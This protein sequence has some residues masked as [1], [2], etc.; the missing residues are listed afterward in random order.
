MNPREFSSLKLWDQHGKFEQCNG[1]V[2]SVDEVVS[3]SQLHLA[4]SDCLVK[5]SCD[6]DGASGL[7]ECRKEVSDV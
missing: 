1:V 6:R 4:F 7:C 5:L 2:I 3:V